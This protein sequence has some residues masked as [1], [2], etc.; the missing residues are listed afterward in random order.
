MDGSS[1]PA[2]P[3]AIGEAIAASLAAFVEGLDP[4]HVPER[5]ALRARY[6]MLD[7]IGCG[8]AARGEDFAVKFGGAF[9]AMAA[10]DGAGATSGVV[11]HDRRLPMRDAMGL[12]GA[13][14]HGLDYDDT[15]MAGVIHLS[16]AV[17]PAV[18]ALAARRQAPGR[19]LLAA[20]VA[21]LEVGA[22]LASV[23]KSGFH[24]RG[25]HPAGLVG[26]FAATM[27]CGHL[28][29]LDRRQLVHAQGIA[30]SMASGNLQFM[31]EGGWTKRIHP[32]WAAQAGFA[33]ATFAEHGV[34]APMAPYTGRFGLF[35]SYVSDA[36]RERRDLA[37]A[38]RGLEADGRATAWEV[39][40]V[41]VKP[42]PVCH[43]LHAATD[44]AIRLHRDGVAVDRIRRIEVPMPANV[45]AMVCEP[46]AY[47]RRPV[48]DYDAKFSLPYAVASGLVRGRLGLAE[49]APERLAE[50][51]IRAVM[52]Q[53]EY[54]PDP[55]TTFPE[56]YTG[57]VRVTLDD[58]RV[59]KHR[60]SVNRGH[61]ER[62]LAND[63]VAAKF[64]ENATLHFP[65]AHADAIRDA[66]VGL[67]TLANS[68]ALEDLLARGPDAAR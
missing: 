66:G 6:L 68:S 18:L 63:E 49:L 51:A 67:D 64:L 46:V 40:Q 32:G 59:V 54:V 41:A 48:T 61:A 20:Y 65:R 35:N 19:A 21:G 23:P 29:G 5:V 31:E 24:V 56:H 8:L 34:L 60:E 33:A 57:E 37:L 38:T 3:T 42:F 53:V 10:Y 26:A 25:F 14:L 28:L 47:K 50:P 4:A 12:N 16:V 13:L 43:F 36:D 39:E 58:G 7:A 30:L 11:G 9:D 27:A 22:R 1:L 17:L 44:S 15:H 45:V 2:A 52:D 62:P 55:D